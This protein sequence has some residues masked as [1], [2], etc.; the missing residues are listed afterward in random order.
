MKTDQPSS[1]PQF[2]LGGGEMGQLIAKKNWSKHELGPYSEWAPEF[3]IALS[4][5]LQAQLPM[6]VYWGKPMYLLYNDA[7]IPFAG[8]KHPK[9]LGQPAADVWR[10]IWTLIAPSMNQVIKRGRGSVNEN[11][12]LPMIRRGFVE[13]SY[14]DYAFNPIRTSD[15]KIS[16]ILSVSNEITKRILSERRVRTIRRLSEKTITPE[17]PAAACIIVGNALSESPYDVPYSLLYLLNNEKSKLYLTATSSIES[18]NP[19]FEKVVDLKKENQRWPLKKVIDTKKPLL[20]E[21]I[22]KRYKLP[23]GPWEEPSY[24]A[25]VLPIIDRLTLDVY[26]VQILGISPRLLYDSDYQEFFQQIGNQT[27]IAIGAA[28]DLQRKLNLEAREREAHNQLQAAVSSGSVGVWSWDIKNDLVTT[29]ASLAERFGVDLQ[30]ATKG[31]P[32][33][34]FIENIHP[35]DRPRIRRQIERSIKKTKVFEAEYRIVAKDNLV[36]WVIARGRVEDDANGKPVRFPGVIVDITERKEIERKLQE[37]QR[38]FQALFESTIIGVLVRSLDG[39]ILDANATFLKMSGFTTRDLKKVLHT[40]MITPKQSKRATAEIYQKLRHSREV[41]P[42][43][44]LIMKKNGQ[45]IPV[46]TG[47]VMIPGSND[48]FLS[49]VLD[50]S[51][52][53]KLLE[54]NKAKDEFISISSHQLRTPATGVKQYLGMLLEGY[55]GE[56]TLSQKNIIKTAYESNERQL[57]IVNDLLR[58]AQADASELRLNREK[59]DIG[60]L[61]QDIIDEYA[62]R[63]IARQQVINFNHPDKKTIIYL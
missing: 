50:I 32:L 11:N 16:G 4:I 44:K 26:G 59:V 61:I 48:R 13:E 20:L 19:W 53:K 17:S 29:D 47:A 22:D 51:E 9:A 46:L 34:V 43:E 40:D 25:A 60:K 55:V 5:C 63:L 2:L 31:L 7:W 24:Q 15:G 58:V 45:T 1:I 39:M 38:K 3:K 56:F 14:F 33:S 54:L 52:Q 10:D 23:G 37:A 35:L 21:K 62:P 28:Y 41:E 27:A 12:M 8:N 42:I 57:K 30:A 18:D 49:F 36:H 6:A